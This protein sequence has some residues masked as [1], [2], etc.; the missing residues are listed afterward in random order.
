MP[1][2]LAIR[3]WYVTPLFVRIPATDTIHMFLKKD[4]SNG[5]E[6]LEGLGVEENLGMKDLMIRNAFCY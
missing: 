5:S 3:G 4:A 1:V 6:H 2:P